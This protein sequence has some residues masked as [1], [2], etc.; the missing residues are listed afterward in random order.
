SGTFDSATG[1]LTVESDKFST[2]AIV[3][4]DV[5]VNDKPNPTPAPGGGENPTPA[6]S[7]ND[8]VNSGE[9]KLDEV[10][11]TG[12]SNVTL[13]FFILMLLSGA[14]VVICSRI[15]KNSNKES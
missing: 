11:K 13:Y 4:K 7:N 12:E 15:K 6:P 2:Y 5:P 8:V 10:P 9:N 14:G 3:Y 1:D